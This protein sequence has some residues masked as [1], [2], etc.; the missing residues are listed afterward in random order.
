MLNKKIVILCICISLLLLGCPGPNTRSVDPQKDLI[1]S[2]KTIDENTEIVSLSTDHIQQENDTIKKS[3]TQIGKDLPV[4]HAPVIGPN[5][6]NIKDSSTEIQISAE[7]IKTAA[8]GLKATS[9]VVKNTSDVV[10]DITKDMEKAIVERDKAIADKNSAIHKTLKW[11]IVGCIFAISICSI[12][13]FIYGSKFGL[14]GAG[15]AAVVLGVSA[16]VDIYF[17][18]LAIAGGII[19]LGVV[20]VLIWQIVAHHKIS[21]QL[22]ETTEVAKMNMTKEEKEKVFGGD[23]SVMNL[24][25]SSSTQEFVKKIKSELPN[26]LQYM[27]KY[28]GG[29]KETEDVS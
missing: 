28:K 9:K 14:I 16:F 25:Q 1:E 10:G 6:Q 26:L 8:V 12:V 17:A 13:F 23:R 3:A 19:A 22:V 2:S 24:I 21:K 20:V 15:A 11:V 7:K 27:K 5:L 18:Y 29:D 4:D